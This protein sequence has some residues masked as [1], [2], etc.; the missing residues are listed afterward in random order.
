MGKKRPADTDDQRR[1]EVS[2]R[3]EG[4]R[5]ARKDR[6]KNAEQVAGHGSVDGTDKA[7]DAQDL[8]KLGSTGMLTSLLAS[9]MPVESKVSVPISQPMLAPASP[10]GRHAPPGHAASCNVP[11]DPTSSEEHD[12]DCS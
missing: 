12:A 10:C 3:E 11:R 1:E 7:S 6:R 2:V 8:A 5:N 4:G 9:T